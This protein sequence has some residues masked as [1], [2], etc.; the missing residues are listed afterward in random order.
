MFHFVKRQV[1]FILGGLFFLLGFI[2]MFLPLLPTVPFMILAA[3]MFA[4]SSPKFHQMLLNSRWFGDDLKLWEEQKIMNKAA[5]RKAYTLI[6]LSFSISI[7][8]LWDRTY[9]PWMLLG[10][11]IL[12]IVFLQFVPD[13]REEKA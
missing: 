1:F 7:Y 10:L 13:K 2:G 6:V 4:N 8:L 9:L 11:A 5:K 12:L 3:A